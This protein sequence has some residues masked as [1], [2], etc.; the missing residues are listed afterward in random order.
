MKAIQTV[1][2]TAMMGLFAAGMA[3]AQDAVHVSQAEAMKAAREKAEPEYPAMA[4][5]LHLEGAVQIEAHISENGTVEEV[6][7]LT[8]NAVLM[9]S[10]VAAMKKWRFT[11]F[12][13]DGKPVKAIADLS[14][15]FKL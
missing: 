6:K 15:R 11:P 2:I 5:Q 13:S 14:F 12:V 1:L 8:G 4:R 10:A 7:P 9:N 3:P